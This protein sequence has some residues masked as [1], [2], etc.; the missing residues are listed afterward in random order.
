MLKRIRTDLN[1]FDPTD[2]SPSANFPTA[3][4]TLL[5]K[6]NLRRTVVIYKE[7]VGSKAFI[8][9]RL[10]LNMDIWDDITNV[11]PKTDPRP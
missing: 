6:K 7:I 8:F 4:P 10:G 11:G 9:S 5:V 3:R 1:G 2:E